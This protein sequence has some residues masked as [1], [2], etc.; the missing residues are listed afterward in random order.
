[1][2]KNS[3]LDVPIRSVLQKSC[4]SLNE[5]TMPPPPEA[6][7]ARR[8][9]LVPEETKVMGEAKLACVQISGKILEINF[10]LWTRG[11]AIQDLP[12]GNLKLFKPEEIGPHF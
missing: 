5:A 4:E 11:L 3:P 6:L 9:A 7:I 1:M 10:K 2:Y 12:S 8:D